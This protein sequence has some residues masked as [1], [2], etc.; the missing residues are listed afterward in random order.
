MKIFK[1]LIPV[2]LLAL[3]ISGCASVDPAMKKIK[4]T[5]ESKESK[6]VRQYIATGE[7]L[8]EKELFS[9][10][11]EQYELAL[12]IDP[13]N[14]DAGQHKKKVLSKLWEKAQHHYKQGLNLDQ[15]GRYESARKEYLA[16]L[17]NWPDYKEAKE[18]LTPGGVESDPQGYILHTLMSGESVS[19]LSMIYY[20]DFKK[21]A[22]I[23]KFNILKDVTRVRI[24]EKLKIPVIEGVS[25]SELK[26]K[27]ATYL[28]LKKP[29]LTETPDRVSSEKKDRRAE[30]PVMAEQETVTAIEQTD[31]TPDPAS[32]EQKT[33]TLAQ[34]PDLTPYETD[35]AAEEKAAIQENQADI[36]TQD[37]TTGPEL[38]QPTEQDQASPDAPPAGQALQIAAIPPE[39]RLPISYDQGV[40]HFKNKKYPEAISLFQA[41]AEIEP[42]NDTLFDYLFKA[43]FQQ[44][45][46]L[47][48]S[49]EYLSARDNFESAL[50]YDKACEKCQDY[51]EKCETTYKEKHYNLGIHYFG[52]EQ[53][54]KAIEQW[55]LVKTLDP[56][57][58]DVTPNLKKAQMLFKKLE[59]IKQSAPQ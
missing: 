3:L 49:N 36:T 59:S 26:Q 56:Q 35:L 21:M 53:L 43:H 2:F 52:K 32:A 9:S 19:K 5:F 27:Q 54:N 57:Y 14:T 20:G 15:Q 12:T 37:T 22:I 1:K 38:A 4:G 45:L 17:Q 31:I 44:G 18:K 16:A 30:E 25:L 47:F 50:K 11:L 29:G 40:E 33:E 28:R 34:E 42:D 23:G 6:L 7:N 10:A 55:K 46:V 39:K 24:G 41:A 58:K 8:E 13:E 48:N 51:I